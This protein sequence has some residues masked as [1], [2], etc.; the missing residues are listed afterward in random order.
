MLRETEKPPLTMIDVKPTDGTSTGKKDQDGHGMM[1]SENF[2]GFRTKATNWRIFVK[3]V[4]EW[5]MLI[6]SWQTLLDR[7]FCVSYTCSSNY[8]VYDGWCAYT[9]LLHA[10]FSVAQFV[11]AHPNFFMRVTHTRMAQASVKKVLCRFSSSRLLP[12]YVSTVFAVPAR[13]PWHHLSVHT[14]LP[15]L[16]VL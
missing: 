4:V 11:C 12:S 14:F 5:W 1:K 9:H 13:L 7:V 16:P 2:L 10:H 3:M 8:S 15:Y 6:F